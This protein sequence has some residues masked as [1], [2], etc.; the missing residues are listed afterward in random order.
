MIQLSAGLFIDLVAE[1]GMVNDKRKRE[2]MSARASTEA[3]EDA[4][5]G[6]ETEFVGAMILAGQIIVDPKT[7]GVIAIHRRLLGNESST[8]PQRRRQI[9]VADILSGPRSSTSRG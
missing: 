4:S 9:S 7:N 6:V 5:Y 1:I 8:T 3:L 2:T